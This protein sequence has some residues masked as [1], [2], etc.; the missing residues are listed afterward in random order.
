M[1]IDPKVLVPD[2]EM[3]R[4]IQPLSWLREA[5]QELERR[6]PA[7]DCEDESAF[8]EMIVEVQNL[9]GRLTTA[10]ARQSEAAP[11][12]A[13]L[14]VEE[15]ERIINEHAYAD[16][17]EHVGLCVMGTVE[18]ASAVH[19]A[20]PTTG[21]ASRWRAGAEAW[22]ALAAAKAREIVDLYFAEPWGAWKTAAWEGLIGDVAFTPENALRAIQRALHVDPPSTDKPEARD[23]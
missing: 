9:E 18:A 4:E 1:T 2:P 6:G 8:W 5:I 22:D 23:V 19:A 20:L 10:L 14:A 3:P 21:A 11:G 13:P 16:D 7:P 15:I 17:I 12:Q